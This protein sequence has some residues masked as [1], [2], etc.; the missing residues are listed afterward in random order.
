MKYLRKLRNNPEQMDAKDT[1]EVLWDTF[2]GYID[3]SKGQYTFTTNQ[4]EL[5]DELIGTKLDNLKQAVDWLYKHHFI[6]DYKIKGKNYTITL[7]KHRTYHAP[8][9]INLF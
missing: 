8:H 9:A 4:K 5:E 7:N 3:E 2:Q 1:A 6:I